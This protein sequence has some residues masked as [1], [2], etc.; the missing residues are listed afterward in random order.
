VIATRT[1]PAPAQTLLVLLGVMACAL[2]VPAGAAAQTV[3]YSSNMWE[4]WSVSAALGRS[5]NED[6]H[7]APN[8]RGVDFRANV[9]VPLGAG[10]AVRAEAG[11][12]SWRFDQYGP[13]HQPRE[14]DVT[15]RRATVGMLKVTDPLVP[16]RGHFGAGLGLYHWKAEVGRFERSITRGAWLAAGLTVPVRERKWA[17]TGEFQLHV[18]GT[19]NRGA[20]AT[21]QSPVSGTAVLS[22]TPSIGFRLFL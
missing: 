5:G 15:V 3:T 20:G 17:I 13:L 10:V 14:D 11:R 12:V 1:T 7:H 19:P 2:L 22:L 16:L 9:E 4:G 6:E 8:N 18:I 21:P